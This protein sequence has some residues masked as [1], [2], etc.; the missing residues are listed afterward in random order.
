MT[1]IDLRL[2]PYIM[3][4]GALGSAFRYITIV[5]VGGNTETFPWHTIVVNVIGCLLMGIFTEL[6]ALYWSPSG[7][8]RVFLTVGFLGGFTTFSSF[9]LDVGYLT[10]KNNTFGSVAYVVISVS[11]SIVAFFSGAALIKRFY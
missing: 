5:L 9:A 1:N 3:L 8:L 11:L 2:L 4:G 10:S 6:M 7:E